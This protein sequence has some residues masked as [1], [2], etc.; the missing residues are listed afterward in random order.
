MSGA[1]IPQII[2]EPI[3]NSAAVGTSPGD[4]TAPIPD[5]PPGS[6]AVSVQGG[7]PAITMEAESAGGLP[8]LGYDENG[9]WYLVSGHDF[10]VQCGQLYPYNATLASKIGGYA[11]GAVVAMSDGS[12][13]WLNSLEGNTGNPDTGAT[14]WSP[15]FAYG[16]GQISGSGGTVSV[17]WSVARFP[18]ISV[19]GALTSNM[20]IRFPGTNGQWLIANNTTG[21]FTLT[22]ASTGGSTVPIPQGGYGSPTGVYSVDTGNMYPSVAPPAPLP[23]SQSATPNTICERTNTGQGAFTQLIQTNAPANL[24]IANFLCDNGATSLTRVPIANV[25]TQLVSQS[26]SGNGWVKL[27]GGLYIQWCSISK[28]ANAPAT[29]NFPTAFPT[30]CFAAVLQDATS[31]NATGPDGW[32][33]HIQ[34]GTLS[35]T[36][37]NIVVDT[38]DG[39]SPQIT[40]YCIAV[41]H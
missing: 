38:F 31:G 14:F 24:T 41:G 6:N 27:P 20:T 39:A 7:Y 16:V 17:P 15:A 33:Q 4:K 37:F 22:A 21:S 19:T 23:L 10:F 29:V 11:K 12:G 35:R 26:L 13:A 18:I 40:V 34:S 25:L 2:M 36:G 8:P 28:A 32:I 1:P 9:L 5:A 30:A 3:A